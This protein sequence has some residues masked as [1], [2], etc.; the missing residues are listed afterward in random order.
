MPR[1]AANL[2]MLWPELGFLDRFGA[3]AR[4]GFDALEFL[5]PYAHEPSRLADL[6]GTHRLLQALFN[7][8]PGNW[9]AGERGIGCHPKRIGEFQDGVGTAIEYARAL[10]C[11][12][13]HA[14]A[15]VRPAGASEEALRDTYVANLRFAARELAKHGLTLLIEAINTRD[16]PGYYLTTSRQAFDI[17]DEVG[18][19]NLHFQYDIYHMQI[20]QGDLAPTIERHLARIGHMQLADTPGRHEP[21]TGEVNVDNLLA[22]LERVGYRGV[23]S[24]EYWPSPGCADPFAWLPRERRSVR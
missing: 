2:S 6:L 1:F 22:T 20:M 10:G 8:P 3:A 9:D 15:G 16:I 21:G 7:M 14:M 19:P 18:A 11:G 13:L 23:V 17:M 24:L 5:F 4:A 12:R